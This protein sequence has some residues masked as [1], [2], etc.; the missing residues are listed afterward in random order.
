V[1]SNFRGNG[2]DVSTFVGG[3]GNDSIRLQGNFATG[4]TI[5]LGTGDDSL[6]GGGVTFAAG[7]VVDGG[8]GTDLVS[9][10]LITAAN[11]SIFKNF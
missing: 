5:D 3:S 9:A 11:A 6:R 1:I 4:S 2:T 8:A 7:M 10:Y